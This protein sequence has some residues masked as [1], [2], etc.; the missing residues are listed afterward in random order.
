M[1]LSLNLPAISD[2]LFVSL[3]SL[4]ARGM[5]TAAD[6]EAHRGR[7]RV[8]GEFRQA[9]LVLRA[10]VAIGLGRFTNAFDWAQ[11]AARLRASPWD[12]RAA[13]ASALIRA[14]IGLGRFREAASL[15]EGRFAS[16]HPQGAAL[17]LFR[18][19]I[20]LKTG[21]LSAAGDLVRCAHQA[22]SLGRDRVGTLESLLLASRIARESG[23]DALARS[24]LDRAN[25]AAIGLRDTSLLATALSERA[26]FLA[27]SGEWKAAT[28]DASR[29]GRLFS[30][31]ASPH[32]HVSAGRRRGL[33]GLAQGAPHDALV[34][35]ERAAQTSRRGF[36]TNECRAEIDLLLADAQLAGRDPEGALERATAAL[37]FFRD[38]QDP[39][40][41]AR[42]HVRRSLAAVSAGRET[43]ALRE[44]R[45]AAS[46]RD[47]GP[48]AEGLADLA[49]GRVL[50]SAKSGEATPAFDRA[51]ANPSLYPPL[52][53]VGSL[54]ALLSRGVAPT[55]DAARAC[56]TQIDSFGDRRIMALVR[57]ALKEAFAFDAP[58]GGAPPTSI[59]TDCASTDAPLPEFLPGLLG[60]S[61]PV[62]RLGELVRRIA[63]SDLRVSIFGETGTGKENVA[64][65]IHLLS[66]RSAKPF[67]TIN[68][69]SLSDEL[70][71]SG[72]F[73][74]VRGAFTGAHTDHSGLVEQAGGGT[75][76]IDEIADL[77]ARAQVRLLRFLESGV[78]RRVGDARERRADVRIVVAANR[79]LRDLVRAGTFRED[80]LYRLEGVTVEIP[81]L[82]DRGS[83]L[84][85]LAAHFVDQFG[86][87]NASLSSLARAALRE[88]SWPG[89]V[90]ELRQEMERAVVLAG[91]EEIHWQ[92][93][94]S[95]DAPARVQSTMSAPLATL[96]ETMHGF[97]RSLLR[98]TLEQ[99]PERTEAARRLGISRQALHQKIL[100]FGL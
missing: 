88:H 45:I 49:L 27:H 70:F 23:D 71:E 43:L 36:G 61:E 59:D 66:R 9:F 64:K 37:G 3:R 32:E 8:S 20:A 89:N 13:I 77:S 41:L 87:G 18:A 40:G 63:R 75:L 54:G 69:A 90:R 72:L 92:P 2:P 1:P 34:S 44:A 67:E 74:H 24:C 57:L 53:S 81:A 35:I 94:P 51:A 56:L 52:R 4:A 91:D 14:L 84:T 78:Y 65:A 22:A 99:C 11:E 6:L 16:L 97:E 39:G 12:L 19:Q 55:S 79:R 47:A 48:V 80:L 100:R 86:R 82:R 42:A 5:H 93:P 73:G 46:I 31:T 58:S 60:E 98:S 17:H 10:E 28:D 21:R 30:R 68:A 33:I 50:L 83:D 26:D 96:H 15:V 85:R 29:S 95:P 25:K 76:F 7:R 38:A 62:R